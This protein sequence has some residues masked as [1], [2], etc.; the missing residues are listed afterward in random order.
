MSYHPRL[1][2]PPPPQSWKQPRRIARLA[3]AEPMI[4]KTGCFIMVF[5][6]S[7]KNGF[8]KLMDINYTEKRIVKRSD[9][10]SVTCDQT[11]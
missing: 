8:P 10:P 3:T 1:I 2:S 7:E 5:D 9:R 6:Q 4:E 11:A